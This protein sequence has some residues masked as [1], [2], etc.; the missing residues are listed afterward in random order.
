MR[1]HEPSSMKQAREVTS[2]PVLLIEIE[3]C[4]TISAIS[5]EIAK[6][7]PRALAL[8]RLHTHPIGQVEFILGDGGYSGEQLMQQ[9]WANCAM[10]ITAHLQD[11][12]WPEPEIAALNRNQ[13]IP[14]IYSPKCLEAREALLADPPLV[15]IIIATRERPNRLLSC[16]NSIFALNYTHYE[17]IVVDNALI[18]SS[19][20]D[21]IKEIQKEWSN[22][23][24]VCE[25]VPGLGVAHNCGLREAKGAIVA[26][27]DD[28]VLVDRHWLSQLVLGFSASDNVACVTGMILPAKL[29]TETQVFLEGF[30]R[31]NKGTD[32]RIFDLEKTALKI[33]SSLSQP[34]FSAQ[35]LIWLFE[36]IF[37]GKTRA[38]TPL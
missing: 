18:T 35:G 17:I 37:Y 2:F 36:P 3:I 30:G 21:L 26:F 31:F 19:I 28:D 33:R 34:A 12:G 38:S 6:K 7:Y 20:R 8:I 29:E 5:P 32:Q 24:Y 25:T 9:I 23:R 1:G 10:E 16:L 27:A 15:S 22:I 4:Q 11:D 14:D 13:P